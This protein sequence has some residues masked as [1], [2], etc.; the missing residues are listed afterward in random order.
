MRVLVYNDI[1]PDSISGFSKIKRALEA[2]N[3]AQADVRKIGDN[4]YRA[5]LNKRDR[6]LFCLYK[7]E[8][9]TV[10]LLLEYLPN[11][12]YEKS[13]FLSGNAAIDEDKIPVVE[14]PEVVDGKPALPYINPHQERFH[15]LDKVISFDDDQQNLYEL[16][17]PLVIVGSAGSGKTALTLEKMKHTI[18]DVLY[19]SLSQYLVQNS[20]NLYFAHN[21][22]NDDQDVTFLSFHEFLESLRVPKGREVNFRDFQAWFQRHCQGTGLNDPQQLYEEFRGVITGPVMDEPWLSRED[23]LNLGI[24]QSIYNHEQRAGVYDLFEKYRRFLTDQ[25]LYDANIISH[26]H[27]DYASSS[28][29]F[30]VIDEVQDLTNI[31]L[32]LILKTLRT[33]GEFILCGDS[34]QIVHPNFF[35]WS[36]IK[37]LFFRE[38]D[39]TGQ[40]QVTRV[41]QSNYRNSTAVTEAANRI[42]KLK[43]ARFGSVDKE[44]NFLVRSVSQQTG[45][46]QLLADDAKTLRDLDARTSKSAHIAVL[47]M[48]PQQKAAAREWFNTPLVFAVQE[49]KGLEYDSVILY[50][51]VSAEEKA[52]REISRDVDPTALE[53]NELKYARVKDKHDKS[54]E[55]YKFYINA[56]YVATT[57]AVKNMYVVERSHD[58]PVLRLLQLDHCTGEL[59]LEAE[60]SSVEEWQREARKL[61][62]QGKEEQA[63]DIRDRILQQKPVPW[64]VMDRAAFGEL[65]ERMLKDGN[66]KEQLQAFE[67]ALIH[68][69]RPTL[70]ALYDIGFKAA[71]QPEEKAAQQ[72]NRAQFM[73]YDF[74]N[75]GAVLKDVEKYGVDHRTRYNLTPLIIA[76]RLGN[77]QLAQALLERGADPD[78]TAN[79][80]FTALHFALEQGLTQPKFAKNKLATIYPLLEPDSVAIQAEGRLIKLDQRLMETFLLHVVTALFYRHLGPASVGN[81][82]FTAQELEQYLGCLPASV[83]MERRKRRSYIS[84]ILSKNEVSRDDPYNRKL[85]K[86][87]MRGHYVVNPDL[88]IRRSGGWWD[89]YGCLPLDDLGTVRIEQTIMHDQGREALEGYRRVHHQ[90]LARMDETRKQQLRAFCRTVRALKTTDV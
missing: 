48:H 9:E 61:E 15:L 80:G 14:S 66:K 22:R 54:L 35:S 30:I 41:L 29:D 10:C 85:F 53:Q 2:D 59:E 62:Q 19:I 69:H 65:R 78:L 47:V 3:F 42:L 27:L 17:P 8:S 74:K 4:L 88:K 37:S 56:L 71:K 63:R 70:N 32:Y 49:A 73:I 25:G 67:Y 72:L 11:H 7:Y 39:L 43:H 1:S 55:I 23:Y 86:R 77:T 76:A 44:S 58:H 21:Y 50:N 16:Q 45:R 90:G 68:H 12:A 82:G 36:S 84:S 89:Y 64:P 52:F 33:R 38:S 6:L 81:G 40:G 34:N 46:L 60:T 18:G 79:N 5:R 31:Q 87:I 20:R 28:Y 75:P 26:G 24:K 13:R 57:R 83:L 51:F